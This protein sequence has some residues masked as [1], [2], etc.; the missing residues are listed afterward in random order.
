MLDILERPETDHC[1]VAAHTF[2][3]GSTSFAV[4]YAAVSVRCWVDS[5]IAPSMK[6]CASLSDTKRYT[7]FCNRMGI[8]RSM[9]EDKV[10]AK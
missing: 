3:L 6:T 2:G 4:L 9:A 5:I 10:Q 8:S 7:L 1:D